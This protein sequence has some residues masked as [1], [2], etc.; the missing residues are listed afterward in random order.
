MM[1]LH[2]VMTS[3]VAYLKEHY[4]PAYINPVLSYS[5][6]PVCKQNK[7]EWINTQA[8]TRQMT[9]VGRYCVRPAL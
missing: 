9:I 4:M 7:I 5:V 8:A 3:L 6:M 1:S 2:L